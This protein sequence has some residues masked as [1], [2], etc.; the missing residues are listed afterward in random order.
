MPFAVTLDQ[1]LQFGVPVLTAL[2]GL[3]V[4]LILKFRG[5]VQTQNATRARAADDLYAQVEARSRDHWR[6]LTARLSAEVEQC[7][8]ECAAEKDA[9]R[10]EVEESQHARE[11]DARWRARVEGWLDS[12]GDTLRKKGVGVPRWVSSPDGT[13]DPSPVRPHGPE[14]VPGG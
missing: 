10:A 4:G 3:A 14:E 8:R 6:E 13:D 12:V 1:F 7:R 9:L 11:S 2:G 5:T